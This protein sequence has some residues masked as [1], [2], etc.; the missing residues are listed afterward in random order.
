M[1]TSTA[2]MRRAVY[3]AFPPASRLQHNHA[4]G[5]GLPAF[6]RT[7]AGPAATRA[8]ADGRDPKLGD[9]PAGASRRRAGGVAHGRRRPR[10][11]G[12]SRVRDR[13][14]AGHPAR[15][16]RARRSCA[17]RHRRGGGLPARPR[18]SPDHVHRRRSAR[19]AAD[20][21]ARAH[22]RSGRAPLARRAGADLGLRRSPVDFDPTGRLQQSSRARAGRGH[23][24]ARDARRRM[25]V[26]RD[27]DRRRRKGDV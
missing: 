3:P 4:N 9:V 11:D 22:T 5:P 19:S 23:A 14:D 17:E 21:P 25:E 18:Y 24:G 16:G 12:R 27:V 2:R 7:R 15:R 20:V 13:R 8:R 6:P 10:G 1:M 26:A